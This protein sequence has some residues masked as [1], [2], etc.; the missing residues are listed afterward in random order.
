MKTAG[1]A[2]SEPDRLL[3]MTPLAAVVRLAAPTTLVIYHAYSV[4]WWGAEVFE[5]R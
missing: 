4:S 2:R 3:A 1:V 5:R